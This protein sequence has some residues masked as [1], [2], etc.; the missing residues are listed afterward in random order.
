[1][2]TLD[3]IRLELEKLL[4]LDKEIT[5][6]EIQAD[7]LDEALA[8]GAV[9]LQTKVQNL[10]YEVLEKG[11]NGILG[12]MKKP[13]KLK[14]YENPEISQKKRRAKSHDMF[15]DDELGEEAQIV[16]KDGYFY[17]RHFG[18]NICLKIVKP[19]G[20]GKPVNRHEI[21]S[22]AKRSDTETF[23]EAIIDSLIKDGT[24]G[25]YVEIGTYKHIPAGDGLVTCEVSKDEMHATVT[26]TAPSMSGSDVNA[27]S[28][29]RTLQ[30]Q[31][32]VAGFLDDKIQELVD[33]PIYNV[34]VEVASAILP[35]DGK[36]AYIAYN[37][38]TDRS[39]LKAKEAENGQIDFKELNLIQNVIAGQPLAT[40]MMPER[41]KV[42]KTLF[43]KLLEAKNGKDIPV[44]LGKNVRLDSDGRT[45]IAE[46]NGQ[47][48]LVGG[49]ITVE[50]IMEL[51]EVNIK[52]G[53]INFLGTVICHGSVDDGFNIK[54]SG[55][56]EVYGSVGNC[57]LEADGDIIV[58]R[59]ITG[60]D[61]G[62]IRSQK[63]VWA[64]FIQNTKVE[65]G[66]SVIVNDYIMNSQVSAKKKILVTGKRAQIIG[67]HLFATEEITAKNI[68]SAGGSVE[69][70]LEVGFDPQAKARL[71]EL[72]K[73][74][75]NM[76]KELD[77]IDTNIQT[78]EEQKKLRRTL[79]MEKE[80]MLNKFNIRKNEIVSESKAISEEIELIQER[81]RELRVVGKVNASGTVYGGV[82]IFIRDV[83]NDVRNDTKC[84]TYYY[85]NGFVRAGKYDPTVPAEQAEKP[86]VTSTR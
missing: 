38:E 8:D 64:R 66:D 56:I 82:K 9:Q 37:F 81:L 10:E 16:D 2:V 13:W 63:S 61:E 40:K 41:G 67:G 53:N 48:L 77:E 72:Q 21:I 70:I 49:K 60:R 30:V 15:A 14:V 80:E 7:T 24:D 36:D 45:I 20:S 76:I 4:K 57:Q 58:A 52:T 17:I 27:D 55:N 65:S 84:V 50:P 59:G 68:G 46:V 34:P 35:I 28:I 83:K 71:D 26:L 69:T 22:A 78:L 79:S 43:G 75:T 18:Q 11:S 12:L 62:T 74:Q 73:N 6:V 85:E 86:D 3:A 33:N 54:A 44:P 51:D 25:Q 39:K 42:G 32:V 29:K 5:F 31:G 47:V 23:N 19:V 1:M